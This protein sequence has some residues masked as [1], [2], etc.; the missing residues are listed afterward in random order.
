VISAAMISGIA[1]VILIMKKKSG[2]RP[3]PGAALRH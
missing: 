2:P 3:K 1:F